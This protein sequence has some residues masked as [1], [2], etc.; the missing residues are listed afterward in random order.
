MDA[1]SL[2]ERNHLLSLLKPEVQQRLLP[3]LKLV[4]IPI[5][6]VLSKANR[7]ISTVYFPLSCVASNL[8]TTE[9]GITVEMATVGNEGFVGVPLLLGT[10]HDPMDS[11]AQ[12]DGEALS[13]SA[14]DFINTIEDG[15]TGLRDI[16][17]LFT[18]ATL[19]Q[20]IQ[21]AACNRSHSIEQ[22]C[23][24]WILMTEE[25]VQKESFILGHHFVSY[26]LATSTASVTSAMA[27]LSKAHLITYGGELISVLDR[28]RLEE[29]S[30]SCYGIIKGEYDRLLGPSL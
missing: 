23:A 4:T 25:R 14:E 9:D 3:L 17:L 5:G 18:Q 2:L 27:V 24:R 15:T 30:C 28:P 19:S 1:S 16:L 7:P 12:I 10:Q 13:M 8:R 21:N 29:A 6:H 11:V 22:R 26:M 20:V